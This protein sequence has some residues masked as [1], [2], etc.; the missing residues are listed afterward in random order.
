M[1]VEWMV[2][3][4]AF[5]LA[6]GAFA[7]ARPM[8][9]GLEVDAARMRANLDI[10]GGAIMSEAVMAALAPHLGRPRAQEV[11]TRVALDVQER[12]GQLRDALNAEPEVAAHLDAAALDRLFDPS[13]H[14]G[15]AGAMVDAVFARAA[16]EGFGG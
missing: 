5:L 8:L 13:R 12:G 16:A 4:E 9:E 7:H 10:G 1:P 6:S 11:V 15:S 2:I 3:P 14:L